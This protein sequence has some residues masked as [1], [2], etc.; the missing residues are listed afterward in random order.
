[1]TPEELQLEFKRI[2][3]ENP[4]GL[5]RDYLNQLKLEIVSITEEGHGRL[6]VKYIIHNF[7]FTE[8]FED[9]TRLITKTGVFAKVVYQDIVT[10]SDLF[11]KDPKVRAI[12]EE[13]DKEVYSP[14]NKITKKMKRDFWGFKRSGCL[15]NCHIR[16][17]EKKK[18]L[19]DRYNIDWKSPQDNSP[20]TR[21]D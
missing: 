16:W 19:K 17:A 6:R 11:K 15:G 4:E 1:M 8:S 10:S 14:N 7:N 12:L 20:D 18:I 2:V 21:F 9:E 5:S 13:V 3:K